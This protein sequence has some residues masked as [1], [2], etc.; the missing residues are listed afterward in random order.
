MDYDLPL[1]R[2]PSEAHSLILQATIGCSHNKCLFCGMYKTKRFHIRSFEEIRKDVEECAVLLPE[3]SKIFLADGDALAIPAP[4][5]IR[6]LD[7]LYD[8]FPHLERVTSYAN[9]GNLLK[10]DP[11]ELSEIRKR[12]LTMLYLGLESGDD[13]LLKRVKKGATSHEI[14]EAC[15][16]GSEAGFILSLT[17]ILGLGGVLGSRKH[18]EE[19]SRVCS[20]IN[21]PYLSA[22]TFMLGPLEDTF[23]KLMG[24]D[25]RFLDMKGALQELRGLVEQLETSRCVFRSNHASNYLPL[26]GSLN[27]DRS[28]MLQVID[29]V[30]DDP[31]SSLLRPEEWRRL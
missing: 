18:V 25:F 12:G 30:L 15:Q 31:D 24:G 2:P 4:Q 20:L 3:T 5:L 11:G 6:L 23:R 13:E 17:V 9:P 14:I 7:L 28:A 10:K 27:E 8:V 19:T 22:L 1:Y 21:P 29:Q 16:K 26:R